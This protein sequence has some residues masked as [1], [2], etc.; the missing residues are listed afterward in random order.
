[1]T[2]KNKESIQNIIDNRNIQSTQAVI[3]QKAK[4]RDNQPKN[5]KTTDITQDHFKDFSFAIFLNKILKNTL[6]F[7][8]VYIIL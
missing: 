1:M 8:I 5:A 7:F 2:T 3:F 4:L 6:T